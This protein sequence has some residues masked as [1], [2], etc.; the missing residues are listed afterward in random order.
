MAFANHLINGGWHVTLVTLHL[1]LNDNFA[2]I[3][4]IRLKKF[5]LSCSCVLSRSQNQACKELWIITVNL[6]DSVAV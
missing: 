2:S 6:T 4:V 3:A 1:A 5:N